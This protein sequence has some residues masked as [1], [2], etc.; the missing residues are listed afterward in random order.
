MVM[1]RRTSCLSV[2]FIFPR[3]LKMPHSITSA[4][5]QNQIPP[6]R[7]PFPSHPHLI[8]HFVTRRRMRSLFSTF[9]TGTPSGAIGLHSSRTAV[10][11]SL[12]SL[13]PTV[14]VLPSV[15]PAESPRPAL[16]LSHGLR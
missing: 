3:S 12:V 15:P 1:I 14:H 9:S 8:D 5:A 11:S 16:Y 13:W 2:S 10:R 4:A 6:D 7:V